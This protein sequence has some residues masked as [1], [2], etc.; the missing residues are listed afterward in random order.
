MSMHRSPKTLLTVA[1][2]SCAG[3]CAGCD[4]ASVRVQPES[5][6][7]QPQRGAQRALVTP[8]GLAEMYRR[9]TGGVLSVAQPSASS[10][11]R[12]DVQIGPLA[13]DLAVDTFEMTPREDALDARARLVVPQIAI[14]TRRGVGVDTVICR[15][16][17]RGT[18]AQVSVSAEIEGNAMWSRIVPTTAAVASFQ[19]AQVSP[20]GACPFSLDEMVQ[21][22]D[23]SG[24]VTLEQE[25]IT[26]AQ[27]ALAATF[28][29]VIDL[30]P[31]EQLGFV[32]GAVAVTHLSVFDNRR[33][34]M[35]LIGQPPAGGGLT[36]DTRGLSM[37][38][39]MALVSVSAAWTPLDDVDPV[40]T[41]MMTPLAAAAVQ[42]RRVDMGVAL[43]RPL[44]NSL[45]QASARAG[46]AC[47]GLEGDA[48]SGQGVT[49]SDLLFDEIAIDT[50]LFGDSPELVLGVGSLPT[51]RTRPVDSA[52][53]VQ[54]DALRVDVWVDVFGTR[55]RV[56][57]VEADAVF[58]LRMDASSQ[59]GAQVLMRVETLTVRDVSLE[60]SWQVEA[61]S[62]QTLVTWS[63]RL[64]SLALGDDISVPLPFAPQAGVTLID[65]QVRD[66]D[67]VLFL[68]LDATEEDTP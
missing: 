55:T 1:L 20:I 4:E 7:A 33:G 61:V 65:T 60:S 3:V 16:Q 12:P 43:S 41:V 28:A 35:R 59:G 48:V 36:L 50:S 46:F 31:T 9:A 42:R 13:Q 26:Y 53:E 52:L 14:P 45:A 23:G 51:L 24:G 30:N 22:G 62:Q 56:A 27:E 49:T 47:R 17:V 58:T 18:S 63:R 29:E 8:R 15:W 34:V 10:V 40:E 11:A 5:R 39:D 21:A 37:T 19:G 64:F 66:G 32:D 44:L 57:Q 68:N 2:L 38:R 25:L 54:W 6:S 67:I